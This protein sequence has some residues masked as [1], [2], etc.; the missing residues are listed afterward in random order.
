MLEQRIDELK[1]VIA[2]NDG[3]NVADAR[4]TRAVDELVSAV[5]DDIGVIRQI[6]TRA[7]F[8]LFVIKVLYVGRGSRH[9]AVVDYLG[10]LLDGYLTAGA[11][12]PPDEH[13]KPRRLYFTD[14]LDPEK[15]PQGTGNVYEAYR[16]YA[17]SA[18][19]IGGVFPPGPHAQ[20]RPR[21]VLRRQPRRAG[22]DRGY[23]VSTGK[24][25]YRMAARD[26]HAQCPHQ[27]ETLVRLA[28]YFE[29]YLDALNE[30]SEHYILGFDMEL[31][32]DKMLDAFNRYR[33]SREPQ[34]LTNARR[35]AAILH[36]DR[37]RFPE[38][39]GTAG[40]S[41]EPPPQP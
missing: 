3:E 28:D 41:A 21:S 31:I 15:P 40:E 7:L 23:Y 26:G 12:F 5:Y 24:A 20:P 33:A 25:M 29:V 2:R 18:L 30:M 11:L 16:R 17:D 19:F 22:V 4:F 35:Y 27:P 14:I 39:F 34:H 36:V 38:L 10:A 6:P 9:A 32:A 37:Q 1:A 13:G 8:D